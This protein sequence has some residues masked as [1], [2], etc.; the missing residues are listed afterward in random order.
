MGGASTGGASTTGGTSNT[1]GNGTGGTITEPAPNCVEPE[2][3]LSYWWSC[4]VDLMNPMLS[5]SD[6]YA[7]MREEIH[8]AHG[9][10]IGS[11][12]WSIASSTL[13]GEAFVFSQPPSAQQ[14]N[15]IHAYGDFPLSTVEFWFSTTKTDARLVTTMSE[16][17]VTRLTSGKLSVVI[18]DMPPS[19]DL[20]VGAGPFTLDASQTLSDGKPHHVATT[21][22]LEAGKFR[23]YVDG[24]LADSLDLSEDII[25]ATNLDIGGELVMGGPN[26]PFAINPAAS[27]Y[28]TGS[29]DEVSLYGEALS[30]EDIAAIYSA[31][32]TGKCLHLEP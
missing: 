13:V 27:T 23:L 11:L 7:A 18:D 3:S 20:D 4:R 14:P 24:S 30:G 6:I 10:N 31:K 25:F 5:M 15:Y 1:G 12:S 32:L 16:R 22:D 26:D 21:L 9:S 28:F 2:E 29:I 17:Y 8:N 19:W